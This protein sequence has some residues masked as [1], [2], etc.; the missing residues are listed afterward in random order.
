MT[1]AGFVLSPAAQSDL[2]EIWD[3]TAEQWSFDQADH[4]ILGLIRDIEEIGSGKKSGR[5]CDDIR[6]GYFKFF[7]GS[8]VV[9][10]RKAK[11]LIDIVRILHQRMDFNRHL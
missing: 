1:K 9:F 7:S 11:P 5:A 8:H 4:Y 10:Y 6:E 3:Y 2:D